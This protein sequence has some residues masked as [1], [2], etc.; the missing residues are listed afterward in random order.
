MLL[1]DQILK[2]YGRLDL[3][4]TLLPEDVKALN[5]Y[6]VA[7]PEVW[8]VIESFYRKYY[9]DNQSRGLILGINPGR[10]GA[11]ATGIPFTDSYALEKYCDLRFPGDT[12]ETSAEFVYLV[13]EAYGGAEKFYQ[14]WYVGAASPLGFVKKNEK[15]NWVNWNYYDQP[16]LFR[17]VR[18]FMDEKL[19]EQNDICKK[20][21]KAIVLGT[22]KNYKFLAQINDELQLF[23]ELIPLEHPRYIMQYRRKLVPLYIDKFIDTLT[24]LRHS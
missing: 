15:G 4:D 17:K 24:R 20:P 8:Q 21:G 2:F 19:K 22:G 14:D 7:S 16:S 11:G 18:P 23:D 6:S 5:P 10:F 1:A 3:P 12:R 13:I 9:S